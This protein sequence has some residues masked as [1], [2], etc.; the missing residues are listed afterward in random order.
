MVS[1]KLSG[2]GADGTR[3]HPEL[4][5][6]TRTSSTPQDIK[7]GKLSRGERSGYKISG[8]TKIFINVSVLS[9]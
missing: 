6:R 3:P 8:K 7:G 9:G 5:E 1:C 2:K 4:R